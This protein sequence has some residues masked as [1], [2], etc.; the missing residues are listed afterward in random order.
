MNHP[1]LLNLIIWLPAAAA[2]A[3]ALFGRGQAARTIAAA[4]SGLVLLLSLLLFASYD[5]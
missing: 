4:I 2:V 1:A 3:I 5:Q